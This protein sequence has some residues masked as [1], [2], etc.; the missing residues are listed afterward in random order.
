VSCVFSCEALKFLRPC[1]FYWQA[2]KI[3][4]AGLPVKT[5]RPA[6]FAPSTVASERGG[7]F[8]VK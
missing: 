5:R 2:Y 1:S 7:G 4:P 3:S 6:K 8:K